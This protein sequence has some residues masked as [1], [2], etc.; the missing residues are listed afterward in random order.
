MD[1]SCAPYKERLSQGTRL[2][3]DATSQLEAR[4][5]K[6]KSPEG[7]QQT[8]VTYTAPLVS[9][10][11]HGMCSSPTPWAEGEGGDG[12]AMDRAGQ[13]ASGVAGGGCV[14]AECLS[15]AKPRLQPHR[16][17]VR[18][19]RRGTSCTDAL[20]HKW[21]GNEQGQLCQ[22]GHRRDTCSSSHH[23][24]SERTPATEQDFHLGALFFALH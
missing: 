16:G 20:L 18:E 4:M 15:R 10:R 1:S 3:G 19:G 22:K 5:E 17:G 2:T 11:S 8:R 6:P 23:E 7:T 21:A 24:N 12:S 13:G 9:T 14:R